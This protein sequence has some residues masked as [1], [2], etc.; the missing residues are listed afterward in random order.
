MFEKVNGN[1]LIRRWNEKM[2]FLVVFPCLVQCGVSLQ[3][4]CSCPP[5]PA[6]L[7]LKLFLVLFLYGLF[8]L[9]L[10]PCLRRMLLDF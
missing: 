3:Q 5:S 10:F 8:G 4:R 6:G 2:M 7:Q 9:L 1:I